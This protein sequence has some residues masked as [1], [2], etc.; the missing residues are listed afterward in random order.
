MDE[1]LRRLEGQAIADAVF[2]HDGELVHI[3][4]GRIVVD[5]DGSVT[6]VDD[7]DGSVYPVDAEFAASVV[8]PREPQIHVMDLSGLHESHSVTRSV[9][10]FLRALPLSRE[11]SD[12]YV[13]STDELVAFARA[14]DPMNGL[15][16]DHSRMDGSEAFEHSRARSTQS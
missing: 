5:P 15:G 3:E 11:L 13:V 12:D 10:D 6:L 8:V 1:S 16:L 14:F 9:I 2:R 4:A 7:A